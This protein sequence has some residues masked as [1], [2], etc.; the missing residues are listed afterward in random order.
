MLNFYKLHKDY[1]IFTGSDKLGLVNRLSSN[2]V[3][4]LANNEWKKTILTTD[5]G[6]FVDLLILFNFGDFVFTVCSGGNAENILYHL[7]KYTIMDDF[8]AKNM[9]GT[10]GSVL[11]F[12][13]NADDFALS[14]FGIDLSTLQ[15]GKFYIDK[16][17]GKDSI[18]LNNDDEFGGF[19]FIYAKEDEAFQ[20]NRIFSEE[21]KAKYKLHEI[22]EDE[23]EVKRIEYGI[24]ES[25]K[26]MTEQTNPLECN[27]EK[28][29]SYTKGCY[30]GQEVI[31]RLDTYDKVSKH[32]VGVI[33]DSLIPDVNSGEVKIIFEGKESGFITSQAVSKELGNIGLGFIKTIFLDYGKEYSVKAD[34]FESKCKIIKLPFK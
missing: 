21:L 30:I 15:S 16:S 20:F 29:I 17:G 10:H 13:N 8:H 5:K 7:D 25:G 23:Y 31:A 1:L 11:F 32:L 9:T 6:R 14:M 18:I 26:E 12:G 33:S 28:Y 22:A 19:I 4:S 34:S 27:L 2:D 3:K 24:P